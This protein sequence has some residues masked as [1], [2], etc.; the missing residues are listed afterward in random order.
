MTQREVL[1]SVLKELAA[2]KQGLPNGEFKMIIDATNSL[3]SEVSEIK[4]LLLNPDTGIVVKVNK[5]TEARKI[6]EATK[7]AEIRRY[8]EIQEIKGWKDNVTKA[9]WVL[10]ATVLGLLARA[11]FI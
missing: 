8:Q 5:N 9:L 3:K 10:F 6:F 7:E 4:S 1:E 11:L 2:I